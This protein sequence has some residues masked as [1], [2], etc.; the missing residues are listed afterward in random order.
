LSWLPEM[1]KAVA[2][3]VALASLNSLRLEE[4]GAGC[5]YIRRRLNRRR[6]NGLEGDESQHNGQRRLL[7]EKRSQPERQHEVEREAREREMRS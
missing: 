1:A 5:L 4:L 6:V 2:V 3:E 7:P